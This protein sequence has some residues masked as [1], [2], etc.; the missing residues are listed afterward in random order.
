MGQGQTEVRESYE[1]KVR[2]VTGMRGAEQE[3][4]AS[5]W[6][7]SG[8]WEVQGG[9]G[10]DIHKTVGHAGVELRRK[11]LRE[12]EIYAKGKE[13]DSGAV[14]GLVMTEQLS[15]TMSG[16]SFTKTTVVLLTE[17][18]TEAQRGQVS[19]PGHTVV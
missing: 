7:K 3:R 9:E 5:P 14:R 17:E 18:E 1:G 16:N 15:H 12:T 2:V 6:M 19:C 11:S 10:G 8:A 13:H 4:Q